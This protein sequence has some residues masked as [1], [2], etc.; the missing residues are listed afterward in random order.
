MNIFQFSTTNRPNY[1]IPCRK[2]DGEDQLS[3]YSSF[4][5]CILI[6]FRCHSESAYL[7]T[8]TAYSTK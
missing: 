4:L 1:H 2:R 6:K 7:Q 8:K 5:S 3:T